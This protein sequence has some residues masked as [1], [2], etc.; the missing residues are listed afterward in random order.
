M[1]LLE[2]RLNPNKFSSGISKGFVLSLSARARDSPLFLGT[3]ED[4]SGAKKNDV[5]TSGTM[6]CGRVGLISIAVG[7]QQQISAKGKKNV[8]M[9]TPLEILKK[10][11]ETH[12]VNGS[13][14]VHSLARFVD[15][16][17]NVWLGDG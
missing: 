1:E 8:M 9:N 10:M 3:L 2:K 5:A 17:G 15:S 16:K 7:R 14:M 4:R 11:L 6:I 12:P 13:L